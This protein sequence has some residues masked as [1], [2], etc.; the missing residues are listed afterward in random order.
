MW[1]GAKIEHAKKY[2]NQQDH[3][4]KSVG[5]AVFEW[6]LSSAIAGQTGNDENLT[7]RTLVHAYD[8]AND[9]WSARAPLP[10][11]I[12]HISSATFVMG[13]RIVVAG[14]ESDHAAPVADVYAYDPGQDKWATLT[15]LPASRF[16]GV[17]G[18]I[19]GKIVFATGSSQRTTYLGTPELA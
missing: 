4:G 2:P 12:S 17:A 15:P 10:R 5:F 18:E 16:S 11:A 1:I 6:R 19:G 3:N 13:G 9:T 14:G 7:T 8:P